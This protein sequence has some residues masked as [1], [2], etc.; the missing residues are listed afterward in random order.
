MKQFFYIWM[1]CPFCSGAFFMLLGERRT[2]YICC[3]L[4]SWTLFALVVYSR[5]YYTSG[6]PYGRNIYTLLSLN[7]ANA[8]TNTL[9][10]VSIDDYIEEHI[11]VCDMSLI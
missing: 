4:G 10:F 2:V 5:F 6:C 3:V 7:L 1:F 8:L 9:G 11:G